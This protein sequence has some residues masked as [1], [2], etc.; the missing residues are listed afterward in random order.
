MFLQSSV[1][2]MFTAHSRRPKFSRFEACASNSSLG[3]ED[4]RIPTHWSYSTAILGKS[5]AQRKKMEGNREDTEH[6]HTH[7]LMIWV[8]QT[9]TLMKTQCSFSPGS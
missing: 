1:S 5:L 2:K 8:P 3:K 9:K 7:S 4:R 6:T